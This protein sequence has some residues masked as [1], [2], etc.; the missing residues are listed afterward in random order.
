MVFIQAVASDDWWQDVTV[1]MLES[2]RKKLRPLIKAIPKGQKKIVYTN[3][4]DEIGGGTTIALPQ[5][6]AGLNMAKSRKR[7]GLS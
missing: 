3:F 2:A 7:P 6:T 4:A 1:P 5:V